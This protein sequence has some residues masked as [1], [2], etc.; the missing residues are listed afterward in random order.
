MRYEVSG[1]RYEVVSVLFEGTFFADGEKWTRFKVVQNGPIYH[2][3]QNHVVP[4]RPQILG[5]FLT[6]RVMLIFALIADAQP[7]TTKN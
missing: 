5:I 1:L 4:D 3:T 2:T 7:Q 6:F